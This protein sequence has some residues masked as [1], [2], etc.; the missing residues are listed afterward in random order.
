MRHFLRI[1]SK[2]YNDILSGKKNFEVRFD[3]RGFKVGDLLILRDSY[4]ERSL[5]V[6]I[7]YIHTDIGLIPGYVILNFDGFSVD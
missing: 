2:Y 3:D 6:E 7:K 1:K 4:F 5:N